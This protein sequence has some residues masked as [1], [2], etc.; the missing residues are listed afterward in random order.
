MTDKEK[1]LLLQGLGMATSLGLDVEESWQKA[2]DGVSGIGK[3]TLESADKSPVQAVG[4][5]SE[6]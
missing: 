5:V 2:L 1:G 3:L 4:E 6:K